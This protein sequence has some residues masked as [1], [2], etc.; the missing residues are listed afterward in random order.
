MCLKLPR[1]ECFE[2]IS[3]L[4]GVAD[5][6]ARSFAKPRIYLLLFALARSASRQTQAPFRGDLVLVDD[7]LRLASSVYILK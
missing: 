4:L 5:D 2:A 7:A 3:P 6:N 1:V